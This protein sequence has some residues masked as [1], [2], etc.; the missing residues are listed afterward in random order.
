MT[1]EVGTAVTHRAA[2]R[3]RTRRGTASPRGPP[4]GPRLFH[5]RQ[6]GVS[7]F[8][9]PESSGKKSELLEGLN[10]GNLLQQQ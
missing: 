9:P 7:D 6:Q 4:A 10:C 5:F 8:W 2:S 1:T 3:N